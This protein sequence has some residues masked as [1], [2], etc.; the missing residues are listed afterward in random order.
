MSQ[1]IVLGSRSR[2]CIISSVSNTFNLQCLWL[3][4]RLS[5]LR[6]LRESQFIGARTGLSP[7]ST[8]TGDGGRSKGAESGNVESSASTDSVD[9]VSVYS[10]RLE[11]FIKSLELLNQHVG[12][13]MLRQQR[14]RTLVSEIQYYHD[15]IVNTVS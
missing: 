6:C 15:P 5:L 7:A 10:E 12:T 1:V 8:A 13:R 2:S 4:V 11:D 3:R 14:S 9:G